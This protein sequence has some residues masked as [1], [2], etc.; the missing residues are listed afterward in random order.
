MSSL[1]RFRVVRYLWNGFMVFS[2]YFNIFCLYEV[3][4]NG[5]LNFLILNDYYLMEDWKD[6]C[7]LRLEEVLKLVCLC[8]KYKIGWMM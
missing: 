4:R 3:L 8:R 6:V 2:V 5:V 1:R 7:Y